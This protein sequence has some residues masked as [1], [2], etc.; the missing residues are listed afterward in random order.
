[1]KLTKYIDIIKDRVKNITDIRKGK[2][3]TY[4]M[5]EIAM[6]AYSIFHMQSSSFL[7]HQSKIEQ[8]IS[9]NNCSKLF[10]F[11]N[12]PSDNQIRQTLDH[13]HPVELK[14]IF[15]QI[16]QTCGYKNLKHEDR[17]VIA[18]DGVSFF[19]SNN[20]SCPC[21]LRKKRKDGT[22]TFSHKALCPV[23]IKPDQA[24]VIPLF[25][26]FISNTDGQTKQDCELNAAK[27]WIAANA[28]FLS[29]HKAIILGDDLFSK[30]SIIKMLDAI[31]NVDYIFVAKPEPHKCMY[32]NL[33]A[34][35]CF[36]AFKS[37]D[38]CIKILANRQRKKLSSA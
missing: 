35:L 6:S 24:Q 19:S 31:E 33:N 8:H 15:D 14:P 20:I 26:E 11:T 10:G 37:W 4:S 5:Q 1:M 36:K 12:V 7:E 30:D 13:V 23:I 38:S 21:C 34:A 9:E 29:L 3:K 17:L 27:R 25:P 22:I 32:E 28:E 16:L 18:I 2:N